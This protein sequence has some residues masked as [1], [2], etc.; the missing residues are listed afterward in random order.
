MCFDRALERLDDAPP[1]LRDLALNAM[2]L[3]LSCLNE[4]DRHHDVVATSDALLAR[5]GACSSSQTIGFVADAIWLKSRAL[6]QSG[7][8]EHEHEVLR[9]LIARFRAEPRAR[10]QV[11]RAMY[12]EGVYFYNAG[13]GE[14]AVEM[15]DELLARFGAEPPS[16][17]RSSRFEAS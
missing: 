5:Y 3:K 9:D 7:E 10:N 16:S 1:G 2:Y 8:V 14:R 4:A 12:N 11:A 17:D 15:W 6:G 13:Q